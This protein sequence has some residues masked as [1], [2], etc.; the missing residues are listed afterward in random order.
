MAKAEGLTQVIA[1]KKN[2]LTHNNNTY[3]NEKALTS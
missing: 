2:V 3:H 1:T